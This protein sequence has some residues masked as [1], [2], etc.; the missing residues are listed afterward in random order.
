MSLWDLFGITE[1]LNGP[2]LNSNNLP[3]EFGSQYNNFE[4]DA[5]QWEHDAPKEEYGQ[6]GFKDLQE[7]GTGAAIVF[8]RRCL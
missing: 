3:P 8:F 7:E 4:G 1:I 2:R 5:W 6:D